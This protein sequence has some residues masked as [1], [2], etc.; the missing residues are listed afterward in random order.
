M[1]DSWSGRT[2]L[3]S[4]RR[5]G[6]LEQVSTAE[7]IAGAH[8]LAL[9]LEER[10]LRP[11]ER[12]AL[13]AEN[14]P[15]WHV[16]DFACH[17]LGAVSVPIYPTL[18]PQAVAYILKNCGASWVFYSDAEKAAGLAE[19]AASLSRSVRTVALDH[20]ARGDGDSLMLLQASG[21]GRI[22]EIPLERF[23]GRTS[24][25][26]TA[27]IIY[28]SGTTGEPKG[29]MLSHRNFVSNVLACETLFPLGPT[30][31]ALS[32]LPLSHV[33]ERTV[34]YLFLLRGV[35]IHYAPSIERVPPLLLEVRPTVLASVPRLY[36][37]AYLRALANV[38][39]E[40][41]L[42]QRI[43]H[44]SLRVGKRWSEARKRGT[45]VSP[46]LALQRAIAARLVHRKIQARFGGRLRF[47]I[48]GGAALGD[49][50]A[51]F[52][53]AVGITLYQGY[54]LTESA[55]V[56][57]VN[58]PQANRRSS[59]GRAIPGVEIQIA[60]DGEILGRSPGLMQ[61][62]W[63]NEEATREA[64]DEEGW[65]H[66]G[67]IGRVDGDGFLYITDRK[68]DI[69]IT[70]GGKNVAPQPIEQL[71]TAQPAIAQVVVVGDNYPYLTA[72][73]V[74]RFEDLP[75]PFA[76]RS[77]EELL[78][79][80]SFEKWIDAAVDAVNAQLSEHERIRNWQYLPRELSLAEG[81][82]T[83][84]LKVRRRVVLER[85]RDL[86]ASMYLKTQKVPLG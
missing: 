13:W 43:F 51:E 60:P 75:P 62:Y 8:S 25:T 15:E 1:R 56:L 54:G 2:D 37:R 81:E 3:L 72:L 49:Q 4:I 36:E 82:M 6:R 80:A 53:D 69:L 76:A 12:V 66:T 16:V 34:D 14:C 83:P 44:W 52:F 35:A 84:T 21:A 64:I 59:V 50:V 45:L 28:T 68:K 29:V 27:S 85:Y 65:L 71:L 22:G 73:L 32:F 57:A 48:A 67:D 33:F 41:P 9:A 46:L 20:E 86:V 63:G 70:S 31:Q 23:R 58:S 77:H 78:A 10:G 39:K 26:D 38:A 18:S 42:K 24:A 40:S 7:F 5:R 19:I 11:G 30:D 79:D 74:P 55:P 17:L 61:G 47:A